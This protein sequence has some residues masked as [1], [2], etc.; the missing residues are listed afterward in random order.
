MGSELWQNPENSQGD[1]SVNL[2]WPKQLRSCLMGVISLVG[3]ANL[4]RLKDKG[5]FFSVKFIQKSLPE[6]S[7]LVT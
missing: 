7:R 2:S 6:K 5:K 4:N 3:D 1:S